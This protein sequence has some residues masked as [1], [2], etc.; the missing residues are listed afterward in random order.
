MKCVTRKSVYVDCTARRVWNMKWASFL[1]GVGA[2]RV[3]FY[4]NGVIPCQNVDSIWQVFDCATTLLLEVSR[5][6]NFVA[7][8]CFWSKFLQK[9]QIWI[10]E[11]HFG[12]VRSD[13]QP[14]LM[15]RW[16]AHSRL[17]VLISW[18]LFTIYYGS[19]VMRQNV[20]S[21]AA[22]AGVELFA[23]QFYLDTGVTGQGCPPSTILGI[24]KLEALGY[25]KVF[26]FG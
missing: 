26:T 13:A 15:A 6:C 4:G 11:P 16:K 5:H 12:E 25:L 21:L 2:F 10:S 23:L 17:S 19:R 3:K 24:R 1:L 14:W 18:T 22:F 7:N 8:F 9:Q 20:Y